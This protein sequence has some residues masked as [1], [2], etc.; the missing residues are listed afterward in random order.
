MKKTALQYE[1]YHKP[2]KIVWYKDKEFWA[3]AMFMGMLLLAITY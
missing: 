1:I 3:T 2:K